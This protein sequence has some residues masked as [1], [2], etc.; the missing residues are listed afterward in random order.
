M[1]AG[2]QSAPVSRCACGRVYV[3][4]GETLRGAAGMTH[5]AEECVQPDPL[6]LGVTAGQMARQYAKNAVGLALM[7][8]KAHS[9][10]K[11]VNGFTAATLDK[12]TR[13]F[14]A[15]ARA[16]TFRLN[17]SHYGRTLVAY[18]LEARARHD[19]RQAR[20]WL[21]FARREVIE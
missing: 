8:K 4:A 20:E 9:T 19:Y 3:E 18:A 10:G 15:L 5:S 14:C 2:A 12:R 16:Y 6:G 13:E 17:L 7:A 11:R 1:R 21:R